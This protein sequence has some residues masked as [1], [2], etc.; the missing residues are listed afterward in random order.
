MFTADRTARL[1]YRDQELPGEGSE[2][3]TLMR[4]AS[5]DMVGLTQELRAD[6]AVNVALF[7]AAV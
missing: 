5:E 1:W 3:D 6:D 7:T 2:H 4:E